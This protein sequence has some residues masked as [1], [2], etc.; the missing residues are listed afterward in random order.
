M[1]LHYSGLSSKGTLLFGFVNPE[2]GQNSG[3][4]AQLSRVYS[5]AQTETANGWTAMEVCAD[6][7]T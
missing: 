6:I 7:R 1:F 2:R 5:H 4:G 3:G